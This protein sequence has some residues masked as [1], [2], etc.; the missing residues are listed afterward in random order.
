M[1]YCNIF[2]ILQC[3]LSASTINT[4]QNDWISGNLDYT[5]QFLT[6]YMAMDSCVCYILWNQNPVRYCNIAIHS[7]TTHNTAKAHIVSPLTHMYTH[8]N[9]L[10]HACT[11][12]H[13]HSHTDTQVDRQTD[14][15]TA[16]WQKITNHCIQ[17]LAIATWITQS[18][19]AIWYG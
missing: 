12:M 16:V 5:L 17:L 8:I 15:H 19:V 11:H 10:T 3:V 2:I 7:N 4:L 18:Y 13:M 9:T 1:I 6:V 14:T